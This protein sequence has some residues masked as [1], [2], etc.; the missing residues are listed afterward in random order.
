MKLQN[1]RVR[2]GLNAR[3]ASRLKNRCQSV[4]I[5]CEKAKEALVLSGAPQGAV[6]GP[7][8]FLSY[9][10]NIGNELASTIRLVADDSLLVGVMKN[11]ADLQNPQGNQNRLCEWV[12]K[13]QVGV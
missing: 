10:N 3:I 2:D 9:L 4:V 11:D 12:D 6:L 1:D 8:L 13:W 7:S 5:D